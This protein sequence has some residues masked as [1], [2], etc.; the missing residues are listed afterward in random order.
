MNS[1][2]YTITPKTLTVGGREITIT[3]CTAT[4]ALDL[5]LSIARVIGGGIAAVL[6]SSSD[7]LA[8]A[9]GQMARQLTL[10]E[11][12]RLMNMVFQY[13]YVDNAKIVDIDSAFCDRPRD[14]W[15][16]FAAC[17]EHNLGPLGDWLKELAQKRKQTTGSKV[18]SP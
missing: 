15:E 16:V 10:T 9:V 17:V 12:K 3:R 7:D 2:P 18:S 1:A 5:E 14:I 4:E 8:A 13:V 6:G 11:L